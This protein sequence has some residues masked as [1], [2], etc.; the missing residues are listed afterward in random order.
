M[1]F[2]SDGDGAGGA[3]DSIRSVKDGFS[4]LAFSSCACVF[5]LNHLV[6]TSYGWMERGTQHKER[7]E[8]FEARRSP[9]YS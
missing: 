2:Q 1:K 7:Y 9:R 3:C 5:F 4:R 8:K 6:H